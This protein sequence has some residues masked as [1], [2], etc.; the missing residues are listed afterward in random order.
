MADRDQVC[1]GVSLSVLQDPTRFN[2]DPFTHL[3]VPAPDEHKA[4]QKQLKKQGVR[5]LPPPLGHGVAVLSDI[6]DSNRERSSLYHGQLIEEHGLDF[7]DSMWLYGRI[8]VAYVQ[9]ND[10]EFHVRAVSGLGLGHPSGDPEV[11]TTDDLKTVRSSQEMIVGTLRG[12]FDHYHTFLPTG[13][14]I[15]WLGKPSVDG[16]DVVFPIRDHQRLGYFRTTEMRVAGLAVVGSEEAVKQVESASVHGA[17]LPEGIEKEQLAFRL[18]TAESRQSRF[19]D[20]HEGSAWLV[21][22]QPI[23][24]ENPLVH[25]WLTDEVRIRCATPEAAAAVRSVGVVNAT[26]PLILD[27]LRELDEQWNVRTSLI[28]EHSGYC[29]LNTS[30][31]RHHLARAVKETENVEVSNP[32]ILHSLRIGWVEGPG[33]FS[34]LGDDPESFVCLFPELTSELGFRFINAGGLTASPDFNYDATNVVA[35]SLV[36]DGSGVYICRRTLPTLPDGIDPKDPV[37]RFAR[38]PSFSVRLRKMFE[39]MAENPGRLW[40]IY[41]HLGGTQPLEETPVPYLEQE[42]VRELQDRVYNITG[43][44]KPAD[45]VWFVRG[46]GMCEHSMLMQRIG[47]QIERPDADTVVIRKWHDNIL[48]CD[49]PVSVNQTYGLTFKV[50]NLAKARVLL[51][52]EPIEQLA[53]FE[54]RGGSWVT[55]MPSVIR[56]TVLGGVNPLSRPDVDA[57]L[58]QLRAKWIDG[59]KT[60]PPL[61][62]GGVLE[63]SGSWRGVGRASFV[64]NWINA[65]GAQGFTWSVEH[66]SRKAALAWLIETVDG[67]RFAFGDAKLIKPI[68]DLTAWRFEVVPEDGVVTVPF[69]DMQ[70]SKGAAPGGPLPMRRLSRISLIVR[71]SVRVSEVSFLR[72]SPAQ[73]DEPVRGVVVAGCVPRDQVDSWTVKLEEPGAAVQTCCPDL[74]GFFAFSGVGSPVCRLWAEDQSGR[75]FAPV[76]GEMT[77]TRWNQTAVHFDAPA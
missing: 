6:D 71:G 30:S 3:N 73:R 51:E 21:P 8:A 48:D 77:E 34:A 50:R 57:R 2:T 9:D 75:R 60:P 39:L 66:A 20:D 26:R 12:D 38:A 17:Y 36:R 42:P 72:P 18:E 56:E 67:G 40:P 28:T 27:R 53:R 47:S 13:H 55:A 49:L 68:T 29:F 65:T 54:H 19:G 22:A 76:G 45:R 59:G 61:N 70:W 44:V 69:W 52:G 11:W 14:R 24:R 43:T 64:P 25:L 46:T 35:P 7:G 16:C 4:W 31:L 1:E 15:V 23:G 74:V 10:D 58:E 33:Q 5:L 37:L 63:L 32:E 41:T 62:H